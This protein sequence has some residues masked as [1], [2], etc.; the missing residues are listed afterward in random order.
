M[1]SLLNL[2][3]FIAILF[4]ATSYAVSIPYTPRVV[5]YSVANYQAGNQNWSVS[6]C[7]NNK[8][9]FGNNSGLLEYDG[10]RWKLYKLPNNVAVRSLYTAEDNR[11]YVGSFEEFGYFEADPSNQLIYYSLKSK[12]ADHTFFND[13][14]WTITEHEGN[15]YFQSFISFFIYDGEKVWKGESEHSPFFFFSL[16]NQL[17]AQFLGAGFYKREKGSFIELFPRAEVNNDNV[18][19]V[20]PFR[21]KILVVT[22]KNGLFLFDGEKVSPWNISCSDMLKTSVTNRAVMMRDSTYIIGTTSNGIFAINTQG[23]KVWHLSR[24]NHLIN[25]TVLGLC[26]DSQDNLWAAL[27]NGIAYIHTHSPISIYEPKDAQIGMVYD[28][29]FKNNHLYLATNQGIYTYTNGDQ[30]PM[31]IPGIDEQTW[32][33]TNIDNQLIGGYNRG[34]LS[35]AGKT[36]KQITGPNGGGTAMAKCFIHGQEILLQ[37]S[38]TSFSVFRKDENGEWQFSHNIQGFSNPI[39]SFEVDPAGNIWASHMYKG[40]YRITLDESLLYVISQ[41]YIGK[42]NEENPNTIVKVMKLRGRIVFTDGNSF[43]TYEDLSHQIVP[44]TILNEGLPDMRDT[45]RI[46]SLN[47]DRF[48]FIR[49][50]EYVLINYVGGQF[51]PVTRIPF[52][53]FENPI[54]EDKANIY[55]D[56]SGNSYFCLNGGIARFNP[57]YLE[58]KPFSLNF[59]HIKAHN[60]KDNK[61]YFLPLAKDKSDSAPLDHQYNSISFELSLPNYNNQPVNIHYKLNG[62]DQEWKKVPGN[63]SID[64]SN[65]PYGNYTFEAVLKNVTGEEISSLTYNFRINPPFYL[66]LPSLIFYVL[67]I[68]ILFTAGIKAYTAKIVRKK[69]RQIEIQKNKQEQQIKEQE[70]LI[71]ELQNE[72]LENELSYKSKELASATLSIITKNDFLSTLKKNIQGYQLNSHLSKKSFEDL[73]KRIDENLTQKDEWDIY[74]KNFD[75]VHEHFFRKLKERYPDLTPGD[76]RMC[77]LLRLNMPTKDMAKLLN[78]SVRGVE[79]ARYRLRKKL[80]LPEGENLI[81]FMITFN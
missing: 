72:K 68:L 52:S 78:L 35:I 66:S 4:P 57:K 73:L 74:Q 36:T 62:Y 29:D 60:R 37:S 80:N 26:K 6:Q 51:F 15:I 41:D 27:D 33:I 67:L 58:Y 32:Y 19:G 77:A 12:V 63:H 18:V 75:R 56:K 13:E 44:Y 3:A 42:I 9:Y 61:D 23:E 54:I 48:W 38:Y 17:Y 46:V 8:M 53:L 65:I 59:T 47:N 76:L 1:N 64:Y 22:A 71:I 34:T 24:K 7:V 10:V 2:L 21:E 30:H 39:S 20:L 70:R 14:I 28:I 81:D 55:V 16:D 50:S 69:N 49:N 25:N 43:Y 5:N 11:I 45:Y 79:G 40:V 31:L